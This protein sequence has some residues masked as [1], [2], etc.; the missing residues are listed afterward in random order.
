[1]GDPIN[2]TVVYSLVI[3]VIF[4]ESIQ[5]YYRLYDN[6]NFDFDLTIKMKIKFWKIKL[7]DVWMLACKSDIYVIF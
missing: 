6:K 1:M 2:Y 4:F 3:K 7:S 5:V